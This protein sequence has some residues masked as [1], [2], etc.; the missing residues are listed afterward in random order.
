MKLLFVNGLVFLLTLCAFAQSDWELILSAYEGSRPIK[1]WADSPYDVVFGWTEAMTYESLLLITP[2]TFETIDTLM[3]GARN[4]DLH[5]TDLSTI[6]S[7]NSTSQLVRTTDRGSTWEVLIENCF[8]E[9]DYC[10]TDPDYIWAAPN[11]EG[12]GYVIAYS[13]DGGATWNDALGDFPGYPGHI[14][15][16]NN[17]GECALTNNENIV[18]RTTNA[19]VNWSPVLSD[20]GT[21]EFFWGASVSSADPN[22]IAVA[23]DYTVLVSEDAGS[24]WTNCTTFVE[25][26]WGILSDPF[27]PEKI[28]LGNEAGVFR[29][30]DFGNT[31]E[32]WE[33]TTLTDYV[34]RFSVTVIGGM[35][36]YYISTMTGIYKRTGE[37]VSGGPRLSYKFPREGEWVSEDTV[38]ILGFTDSEGIDASTAV[39]E[40][41]GTSYTT[42]DTE[43]EAIGDTLFYRTSTPFVDGDVVV[44]LVGIEDT[45]GE[46]SADS[47][48][49]FTFHV[50]KTP[51]EILFYEPDSGEILTE[52]PTGIMLVFDDTGCGNTEETWD[53][54]DGTVTL[55]SWSS[56]VMME[57]TDTI[58][59][60]FTTAGVDIEVGDTVTFLFR[61]WDNPDIGEPNIATQHLFFVVTTGIGEDKLPGQIEIALFP[62]PFNGAC[63]ITSPPDAEIRIYDVFGNETERLEGGNTIWRP[64]KE[65]PSGLYSIKVSTVSET[66]ILEAIYLK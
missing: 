9:F 63:R 2:D 5:P 41:D 33:S 49:S 55:G 50:D 64:S 26:N 57:G 12:V 3:I 40:V 36:K 14:Y 45:G 52:V 46:A 58:F 34:E 15:A 32:L 7:I 59:I 17:D 31:W 24:S 6:L 48:S 60:D 30:S 39:I 56:G 42:A 20:I 19:G 1:T 13:S 66:K 16:L 29:S 37:I 4:L 18:Y 61:G 23:Y 53:F 28:I 25:Y 10:D 11:N 62:N 27:D 43:L 44:T 65:I 47:G 38:I 54:T 21:D 51:P 22:R 35:R 8:G